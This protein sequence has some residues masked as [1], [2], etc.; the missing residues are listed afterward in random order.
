MYDGKSGMPGRLRG[1]GPHG[2]GDGGPSAANP[3]RRYPNVGNVACA[4]RPARWHPRIPTRSRMS[5]A[6][7]PVPTPPFWGDRIVK[8]IAMKGTS[9]TSTNGPCSADSG[10]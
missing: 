10:D 6:T 9:P 8:G 4:R 5:P 2:C 3:G 7:P 1:P